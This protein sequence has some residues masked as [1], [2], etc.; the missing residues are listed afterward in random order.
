[1][2]KFQVGV[3][4]RGDSVTVAGRKAIVVSPHEPEW[5]DHKT[6]AF[7]KELQGADVKFEDGQCVYV[8][9]ADLTPNAKINGAQ[10]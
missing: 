4:Q 7:C 10:P 6:R 5:I 2:N 1:M 9:A 3:L 8:H